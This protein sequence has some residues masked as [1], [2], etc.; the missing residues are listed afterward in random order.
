LIFEK[1][2]LHGKSKSSLQI[3]AAVAITFVGT[4]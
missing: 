1:A 3:F 2:C 4:D